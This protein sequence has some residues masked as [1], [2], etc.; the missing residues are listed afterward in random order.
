MRNEKKYVSTVSTGKRTP[1]GHRLFIRVI[2]LESKLQNWVQDVELVTG[3][4]DM[5]RNPGLREAPVNS[6]KCVA[7]KVLA[8]IANY[9]DKQLPFFDEL[10]VLTLSR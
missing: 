1:I 4:L 7:Q 6:L 9:K 10:R 3:L 2:D 8:V 5:I